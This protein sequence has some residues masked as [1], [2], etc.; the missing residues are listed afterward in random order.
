M[1]LRVLGVIE[2][3]IYKKDVVM[4]KIEPAYIPKTRIN[5]CG[6][7]S[8]GLFPIYDLSDSYKSLRLRGN[9]AVT[10]LSDIFVGPYIDYNS[11]K[12]FKTRSVDDCLVVCDSDKNGITIYDQTTIESKKFDWTNPDSNQKP[13]FFEPQLTLFAKPK[14]I[15]EPR[16]ATKEQSCVETE[17]FK[18]IQDMGFDFFLSDTSN[19]F[20]KPLPRRQDG[21]PMKDSVA[22]DSAFL[23]KTDKTSYSWYKI[24]SEKMSFVV[25]RFS[26]DSKKETQTINNIAGLIKQL[27]TDRVARNNYI[28]RTYGM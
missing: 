8:F 5:Q 27:Q 9:P 19:R 10:Q 25:T 2:R 18:I 28:K 1:R 21:K 4:S 14:M 13:I 26:K 15:D 24:Y 22:P 20:F 3:Q 12:G 23:I 16:Y 17:V 7:G 6:F 11:I